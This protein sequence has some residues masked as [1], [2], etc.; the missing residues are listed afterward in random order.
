MFSRGSSKEGEEAN[1]RSFD[2]FCS[3]P[4][5]AQLDLF[6]DRC[7][8]MT[9]AIKYRQ[10]AGILLV[11]FLPTPALQCPSYLHSLKGSSTCRLPFLSPFLQGITRGPRVTFLISPLFP[12]FFPNITAGNL[13]ARNKSR[14]IRVLLITALRA[15]AFTQ[16]RRWEAFSNAKKKSG[17]SSRGRI[18]E[19]AKP[20]RIAPDA[21]PGDTHRTKKRRNPLIC[22]LILT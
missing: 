6:E 19:E 20:R 16:W 7:L 18:Y 2:L 3:P 13:S 9:A 8:E 22:S 11:S 10:P 12:D 4:S 5:A 14:L 1:A 21:A 17:V 15:M